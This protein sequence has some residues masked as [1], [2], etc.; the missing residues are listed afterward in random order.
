MPYEGSYMWNLRQK[1]G[2]EKVIM[3]GV[4]A[5]IT[6][7]QERVLLEHRRDFGIWVFPGGGCEL[8]ET[9]MEA[10][11][12]EVQE[13]TG[14]RVESAEL[15]GLY[16]DPRYD[17]TYPNGDQI[18]QFTATFHVSRWSGNLTHDGSESYGVKWWPIADMPPL[19][20]A[21]NPWA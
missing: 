6:D 2:R 18:Q 21:G 7:N 15:I 4:C 11:Q 17:V 1:V 14:L 16:T 13:E 3:P 9:V 8:G 5:V 10:L 20:I 12:R 19:E